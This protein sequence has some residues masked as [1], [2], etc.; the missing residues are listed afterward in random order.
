[1]AAVVVAVELFVGN[2][3]QNPPAVRHS[4]APAILVEFAAVVVLL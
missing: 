1:M 2:I 4:A 3:E